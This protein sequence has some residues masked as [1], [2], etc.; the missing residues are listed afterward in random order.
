V[1][2]SL[3]STAE[4]AIRV[5][6]VDTCKCLKRPRVGHTIALLKALSVGTAH[7]QADVHRIRPRNASAKLAEC[8]DSSLMG[9]ISDLHRV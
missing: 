2:E 8:G 1:S 7:I 5:P 6:D 4:V 9:M 3:D